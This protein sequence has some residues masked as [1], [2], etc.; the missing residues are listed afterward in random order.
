MIDYKKFLKAENKIKYRLLCNLCTA[1]FPQKFS[2]KEKVK[3][4]T[5]ITEYEK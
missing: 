5:I 4:R 2:A 1:N 3:Q